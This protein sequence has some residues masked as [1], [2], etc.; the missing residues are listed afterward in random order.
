MPIF[1]TIF[2]IALALAGAIYTVEKQLSRNEV[3]S[4]ERR[5]IT[6]KL[7][8]IAYLPLILWLILTVTVLDS[9]LPE[10]SW[11]MISFLI[12]IAWVTGVF[13]SFRRKHFH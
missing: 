7:F 9:L 11:L 2:V 8:V 5:R 13:A 4:K 1:I 10:R 3:S 12:A 6:I